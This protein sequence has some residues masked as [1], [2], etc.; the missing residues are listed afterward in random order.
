MI[1]RYRPFAIFLIA[2]CAHLTGAAGPNPLGT[3][4]CANNSYSDQPCPGGKAI[5]A[6]DPRS[7]ADRRA[8]EAATRR[9]RSAA[10]AL[11][12]QRLKREAL[13]RRG[14]QPIVIGKAPAAPERQATKPDKKKK[15]KSGREPEYF[16][17]HD[18]EA[19]HSNKRKK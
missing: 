17:A 13:A 14:S 10:E 2:A 19:A 8:A 7:A 12:R 3:W 11:E 15:K 4:R 18:P 5:D 6:S 16:T 9:E 1:D